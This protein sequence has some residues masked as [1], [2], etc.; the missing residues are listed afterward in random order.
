MQERICVVCGFPMYSA[1]VESTWRCPR[2]GAE[3]PP[4][5]EASKICTDCKNRIPFFS[6]FCPGIEGV[7]TIRKCEEARRKAQVNY[8]EY[9][10]GKRAAMGKY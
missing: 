2:C 10:R 1:A 7:Y 3:V 6:K 9:E 4:L 8:E 5:P